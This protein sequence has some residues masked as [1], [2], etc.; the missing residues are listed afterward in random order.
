MKEK[1]I[2]GLKE[3][4]VG[5]QCIFLYIVCQDIPTFLKPSILQS[6]IIL[7]KFSLQGLIQVNHRSF[8]PF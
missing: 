3:N 4:H 5:I 6:K 2:S 8:K 1:V 7:A